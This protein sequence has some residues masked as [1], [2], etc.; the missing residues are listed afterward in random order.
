MARRE[1]RSAP[2]ALS[3][4]APRNVP[5]HLVPSTY[6]RERPSPY[7]KELQRR[8]RGQPK[9]PLKLHS[10]RTPQPKGQGRTAGGWGWGARVGGWVGPAR[11]LCTWGE[12]RQ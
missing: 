4:R 8:L 6:E 5:I 1:E 10:F 2:P 9:Q 3:P 7:A 12:R 11:A